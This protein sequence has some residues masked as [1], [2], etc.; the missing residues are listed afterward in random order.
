MG[1]GGTLQNDEALGV[2]TVREA[3]DDHGDLPL[4]WSEGP[5]RAAVLARWGWCGTTI[6]RAIAGDADQFGRRQSTAVGTTWVKRS[7]PRAT[8]RLA[9]FSPEERAQFL[10]LFRRAVSEL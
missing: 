7:A 1:I 6:A 10:S 3:L 4:A 2:C 9:P 8:I 5:Q